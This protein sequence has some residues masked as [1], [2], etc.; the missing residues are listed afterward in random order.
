MAFSSLGL[1]NLLPFRWSLDL[2]I[3]S[4]T[5]SDP[6]RD[7]TRPRHV[8]SLLTYPRH[9]P[10]D[11]HIYQSGQGWLKRD[12]WGGIYCSPMECL[13]VYMF[14]AKFC[15][16]HGAV[17]LLATHWKTSMR[18]D[19]FSPK[20]SLP[21]RSASASRRPAQARGELRVPSDEQLHGALADSAVQIVEKP[22]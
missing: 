13:G 8:D 2:V 14:F 15:G 4:E 10:W 22:V 3:S 20:R 17:N 7:Q 11:W 16:H 12:Q 9:D 21:V 18:C 1:C 19:F 6:P 5:T